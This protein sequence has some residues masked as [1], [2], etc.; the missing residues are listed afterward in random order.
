MMKLETFMEKV[1]PCTGTCGR[2]TRPS[3]VPAHPEV[4]TVGRV[5]QGQCSGCYSV[6]RRAVKAERRAAEKAAVAAAGWSRPVD[7]DALAVKR[8]DVGTLEDPKLRHVASGLD[9]FMARRQARLAG[10]RVSA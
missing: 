6:I 7:P 2:L 8:P 3:R 10:R 1:E 9:S 5:A 4:E